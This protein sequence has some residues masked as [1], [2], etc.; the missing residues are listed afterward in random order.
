MLR[1]YASTKE[2]EENLSKRISSPDEIRN[3]TVTLDNPYDQ[4]SKETYSI[5]IESYRTMIYMI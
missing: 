1:N 5:S 3:Y 2:G 4:S